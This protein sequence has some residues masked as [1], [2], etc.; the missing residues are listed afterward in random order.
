MSTQTAT[1]RFSAD[2][3]V[4]CSLF[5]VSFHLMSMNM[6]PNRVLLPS[7]VRTHGVVWL[8]VLLRSTLSLNCMYSVFT[9]TIFDSDQ[10][11]FL[12]PHFAIQSKHSSMKDRHKAEKERKMLSLSAQDSLRYYIVHICNAGQLEGCAPRIKLFV[13]QMLVHM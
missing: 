1:G 2:Y 5:F 8:A 11:F 7:S 4:S 6:H 10:N 13:H 3:H 12:L 9:V